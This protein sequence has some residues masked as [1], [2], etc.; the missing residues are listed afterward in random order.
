MSV[1]GLD[2]NNM[3]QTVSQ[4]YFVYS[5]PMYSLHMPPLI[6]H[7]NVTSGLVCIHSYFCMIAFSLA[8]CCCLLWAVA[9]EELLQYKY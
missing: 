8:N 5:E 3:S 6:Q 7:A 9:W 1:H 4:T 2:F